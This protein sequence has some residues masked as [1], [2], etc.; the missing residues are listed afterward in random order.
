MITLIEGSAG[1]GKTFFLVNV[2]LKKQWQLGNEIF[3]NFPM[4]F[5]EKKSGI[6]R[7][8]ILDDTFH[9]ENGIIAIDESQKLLDARRWKSLPMFFT[10]K[11]AEHRH[12]HLDIITTTQDFSHIDVRVRTNVHELY[13]CQTLIRLP[14]NQRVKPIIH[15]VR[16]SKKIRIRTEE[17]GR[18]RW[19]S[20]GSMMMYISK[21]W[22]K[23]YY[24]TY[25]RDIGGSEF[26]TK[27]KM[28][29][30]NNKDIWKIKMFSRELV[31][32]GK[33]KI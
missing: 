3:P 6:T 17:T 13:T 10:E 19:K 25:S 29:T 30:K 1:S 12:E 14:K 11:I 28:E 18:M 27:I 21:Y 26:I 15:I 7:W 9:L 2:L 22:S 31:N 23:T 16:V 33:A 20:M 32:K 24:D 4:A 5:D 8:H